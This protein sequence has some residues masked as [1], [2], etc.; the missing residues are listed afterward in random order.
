MRRWMLLFAPPLLAFSSPWFEGGFHFNA[1]Y[2]VVPLAA[3]LGA[4]HGLTGV[5]AT[6]IGGLAFVI[7]F[8]PLAW[9][10]FGGSPALYLIAVAVAAI[11]A[12]STPYLVWPRW[13]AKDE[14]AAWLAF[15]APFLLVVSIG[16]TGSYTSGPRVGFHFSFALLGYFLIFAMGVRGARAWPL[17]AG[18]ALAAALTWGLAFYGLLGRPRG[19]AYASI[20]VLQPASVLAAL[21]AYSGGGALNAFL[22]GRPASRF[23]QRPYTATILLLVLWF[24][25]QPLDW[26]R[27]HIGGIASIQFLQA[28]VV[29][30]IAAFTA[31]LL[32][33][34]RGVVFV[35]VLAPVLMALSALGAVLLD[36]LAGIDL[37]WRV[38]LEAPFVAAAFG[39][40]GAKV[41]QARMGQT[42]SRSRVPRVLSFVGLLV[43]S[44]AAIAGEGDSVARL[45]LAGVFAVACVVVFFMAPRLQAAMGRRGF[46]LTADRWLGFATLLTAVIVVTAKLETV[47][48][49][50]REQYRGFVLLLQATYEMAQD[51]RR[52]AEGAAE[53]IAFAAVFGVLLLLVVIS[54]LRNTARIVPKIYR[55]L[56]KIAAFVRRLRRPAP[57]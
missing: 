3:L 18:L 21:A 44:T 41:A 34:T 24:G 37:R 20:G 14:A 51:S 25:P 30:P 42:E 11:S 23:W 38:P 9:G 40:L 52:S 5:I 4:R 27:V 10:Y 19:Q 15:A 35:T 46:Q 39:A 54:A 48:G 22:R 8:G 29:L 7:G 36:E 45:V 16:A 6:A 26:M 47:V 50:A 1:Q 33:S 43:L 53:T 2:L 17:A 28:P 57:G 49:E 32:R 31:G 13:P 12:S 56:L 55:D